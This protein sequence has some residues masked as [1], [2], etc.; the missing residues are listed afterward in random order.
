MSGKNKKSAL[1]GCEA[2]TEPAPPGDLTD[3]KPAE[4]AMRRQNEYL[5]ALHETLLDVAS[6]LDLDRLLENI[7]KRA[8]QLMG[9]ST[10]FLDM[11]EPGDD[12]LTPKFALGVLAEESVKFRNKPGEGLGGKV[13]QTGQTILVEDYDAWPGRIESHQKSL[14]RSIVAAPLMSKSGF[15]GVLGLAHERKSGRT[16]GPEAVRQLDQFA[17]FAAIAIENARLYSAVQHELTR[18]KEAEEV[19]RRSREEFK[20][21]F[22]NAPVGYHELDSEGRIFRINNTE[23]KMLG[24]SA[25]EL[26]GQFVWKISTDEN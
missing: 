3:Y 21:L 11:L 10:G 15:V 13:W 12:H 23:L 18:R 16:F 4:K 1:T 22:D 8:A 2:Q 9:T 20:D 7:L 24:Y 14:I 19:L 25:G 26:I 5:T 6:Q 17:R